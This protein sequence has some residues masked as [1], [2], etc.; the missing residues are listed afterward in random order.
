MVSTI[1]MAGCRAASIARRTAS[2]GDVTP[3]EV[4]L[5]TTHTALMAWPLS[6]LRR[7]SIAA[8]STPLRQSEAIYSASSPSFTA[9][10][11]HSVAKWPVSY[12][13]TLSPGESALLSAASHA[14]V[15]EDGK[16]NTALRVLNTVLTPASTLRPRRLNS[17]PR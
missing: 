2:I 14:P 15:P 16:I 13:R 7:A 6:A 1:S 5:C 12:I 3:V 11:F 8:G 4:S 9:M 10:L 17:G